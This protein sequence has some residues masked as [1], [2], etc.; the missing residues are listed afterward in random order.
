MPLIY[1]NRAYQVV[2]DGKPDVWRWRIFA[3]HQP[4]GVPQ[5]AGIGAGTYLNAKH[6]ACRAIDEWLTNHPSTDET[7]ADTPTHS[8]LKP[9]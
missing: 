1:R 4:V 2:G 5:L 7:G 9:A 6:A 8:T 3:T